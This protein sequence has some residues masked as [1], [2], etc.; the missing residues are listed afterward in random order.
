MQPGTD[1]DPH[2]PETPPAEAG[3]RFRGWR[4]G[5]ALLVLTLAVPTAAAAL[6]SSGDEAETAETPESEDVAVD[7]TKSDEL[8][9]DDRRDE[10]VELV[11]E[12]LSDTA[13]ARRLA[14]RI[15][16]PE[17]EPAPTT[18]TTAAPT[19]TTTA[20]PTTTTAPP[21]PPP[22]PPP[23]AP[24]PAPAPSA[25]HGVWD[26]LAACE[27]GGNWAINTGNGY[28]GGLQFSLSSWQAVG[29][30]GYPHEHSREVQIQMGERLKNIQGWGA[31]PACTRKL[32]LR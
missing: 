16:E 12:R 24:E 6:V 28:Y 1:A 8:D 27:S 10:L 17:P 18:T 9:D 4:I 32:G 11:V 19:T 21:P 29:G 5:I 2:Q 3:R 15:P 23:P 22:P 14:E 20:A 25:G 7:E 13:A 31:W 30:T 26:Q